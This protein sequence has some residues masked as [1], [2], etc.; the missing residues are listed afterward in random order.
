MDLRRATHD[1][2]LNDV[3]HHH[4]LLNELLPSLHCFCVLRMCYFGKFAVSLKIGIYLCK[5][6]K[7]ES[8]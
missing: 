5:Q 6:K 8:L 4:T 7:V 3:D 2:N 1:S